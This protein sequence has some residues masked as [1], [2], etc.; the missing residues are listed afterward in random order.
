MLN[1]DKEEDNQLKSEQLSN[2]AV[3]EAL[4]P[5]AFLKGKSKQL[6]K[7][8]ALLFKNKFALA[9]AAFL[10]LFWALLIILSH[11]FADS[12]I[13]RTLRFLTLADAGLSSNPLHFLGGTMAKGIF[14]YFLVSTL[15]DLKK[16]KMP[17]KHTLSG[18]RRV[19]EFIRGEN[20]NR[21]IIFLGLGAALIL[22]NF[23]RANLGPG[24]SIFALAVSIMSLNALSGRST[25]LYGFIVS[26]YRQFAKRE[27]KIYLNTDAVIAGLAIG[28]LAS[29]LLSMLTINNLSYIL[30]FITFVYALIALKRE[31]VA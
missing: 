26:L 5:F 10:A 17:F 2:F 18:L 11:F 15:L 21:N 9:A 27:E 19:K 23:F 31:E 14:S 25:F 13:L 30:G 3:P 8:F 24:S 29:V 7:N 1:V 16:F 12:F 4:G 22:F 20:F 28:F 6:F